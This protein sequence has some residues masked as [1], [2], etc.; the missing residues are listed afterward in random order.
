M[1]K[2]ASL[3]S[4]V[5]QLDWSVV[6]DTREA[7]KDSFKPTT[8]VTHKF[9]CTFLFPTAYFAIVLISLTQTGVCERW[10]CIIILPDSLARYERLCFVEY[11]TVGSILPQPHFK[12]PLESWH[13]QPRLVAEKM[14]R[15]TFI[16]KSEN[17]G[18]QIRTQIQ[19][20]F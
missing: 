17:Y 10:S 14:A 20:V 8:A 6:R 11:C 12:R 1:C 19:P 2:C 15:S 7:K 5:L 4:Y 18:H 9:R 16:Y 3:H 13:E